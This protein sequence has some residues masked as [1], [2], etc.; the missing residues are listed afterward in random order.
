MVAFCRLAQLSS[1]RPSYLAIPESAVL[2]EGFQGISLSE[3]FLNRDSLVI[4]VV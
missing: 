2:E 1:A 3:K 4:L